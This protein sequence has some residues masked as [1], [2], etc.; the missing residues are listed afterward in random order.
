MSE[1]IEHSEALSGDVGTK[2]N[3]ELGL[4]QLLGVNLRTEPTSRDGAK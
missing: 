1:T 3:D 4:L 2:V